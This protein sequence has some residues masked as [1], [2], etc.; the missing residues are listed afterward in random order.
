MRPLL[1]VLLL[2]PLLL[3]ACSSNPPASN[4]PT[5]APSAA[6]DV[7]T[8]GAA[9]TIDNRTAFDMDI[10]VQRRDGA[11]R[12][13]FA[14]AKQ[15]TRFTLAPGLIAGSGIVEFSARPTRGGESAASEP[16]TVH[17]GDELTWVIPL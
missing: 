5:P 1:A 11:V 16:F 4:P 13:G 17:P 6:S 9:V 12:L 2:L 7:P 15:T 8:G 10:Y 14:P 3:P